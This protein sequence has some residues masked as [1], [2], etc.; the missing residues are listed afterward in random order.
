MKK[1][2]DKIEVPPL[3][4]SS[5]DLKA[6][7]QAI[8]DA[9]MSA[10]TTPDDAYAWI[11]ELTDDSATYETMGRCEVRF[12]NLDTKLR[13]AISKQVAGEQASKYREL[14]NVIV[15]ASEKCMKLRVPIRG[16]QLVQIIQAFYQIDKEKHI[17]YDLYALTTM[18]YPGDPHMPKFLFDWNNMLG[19][20]R[21]DVKADLRFLELVLYNL[22]G[23]SH[24]MRGHLEHYDRQVDDHPDRSYA[25]LHK[26][27]GKVVVEKRQRR[28]KEQLIIEQAGNRRPTAAPATPG[29][30][31]AATDGN[32]SDGSSSGGKAKRGVFKDVEYKDRCCIRHLWG[33]CAE[34][35]ANG[36]CRFGPH[37]EEAPDVVKG[38]P[39]YAIMLSE[40]GAPGDNA[41]GNPWQI[42][43][44]GK[45]KKGRG[46]GK[47]AAPA[48]GGEAAQDV[49][50]Q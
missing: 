12:L 19:N 11:L 1:E 39:L 25:Y 46:K 49:Q 4:R 36:G 42:K 32:N 16:R 2:A 43:G 10:S 28:N 26:M 48:V 6:W 22:L 29:A 5:A 34:V 7:S 47:N 17:Q 15:E 27:L 41:I 14:A 37:S 3:V 23:K 13:S 44:A 40:N 9:V 20:M 24:D 35:V 18:T 30:T 38:H 50:E 31:P 21:A 8:Y 45:G 33:K